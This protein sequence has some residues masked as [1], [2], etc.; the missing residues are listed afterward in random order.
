MFRFLVPRHIMGC[1]LLEGTLCALRK[2]QSQLQP[3]E[4]DERSGVWR[5][6]LRGHTYSTGGVSTPCPRIPNRE[7][8][9]KALL[10]SR[11]PTMTSS[12]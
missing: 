2:K 5:N 1:V 10:D 9:F 4:G 7:S 11:P 12:R 8:D 3:G 6:G